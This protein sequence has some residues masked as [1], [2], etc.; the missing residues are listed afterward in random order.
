MY[1]LAVA[2]GAVFVLVFMVSL[3]IVKHFSDPCDSPA[4]VIL[5]NALTL[6]LALLSCFA[7]PLDVY[8]T[9]LSLSNVAFM[10]N[11][12]FVVFALVVLWVCLVV[13]FNYFYVEEEADEDA[14]TCERMGNAA[15]YTAFFFL[16]MLLLCVIGLA[17]RP[18]H[19][20]WVNQPGNAKWIRDVFDLEHAGESAL[21]FM[22]A[23]LIC[24]GSAGWVVYVGYGI[25]AMPM[26]LIRGRKSLGETRMEL[27]QDLA[28]V[29][30]RVRQLQS[31]PRPR[32]RDL[33]ELARLQKQE[34]IL[35]LTD[36]SLASI[37]VGC[38]SR[39]LALLTP[40]RVLL[41]VLLLGVSLAVLTSLALSSVDKALH[42]VC[43]MKCGFV[44]SKPAYFNPVDEALVWL[45]PQFPLDYAVFA[46]LV[47]FLFVSALYGVLTLGV[48]VLCFRVV[49]VKGR[50]TSPQGMLVACAVIMVTLLALNAELLALAPQYS[51]FGS[52]TAV[53]VDANS[54]EQN[55]VLAKARQF[56]TQVMADGE[57][58]GGSGSGSAGSGGSGSSSHVRCTIGGD[59]GEDACAMSSMARLLNSITMGM[60]FFSVVFYFANWAFLGI[61]ALT[62]LW[63]CLRKKDAGG[64][65]E[66]LEDEDDE[67]AT[68]SLL[69]T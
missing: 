21:M 36:D 40:F 66:L 56:T 12:Y 4:K 65:E 57:G 28:K 67:E 55:A 68:V 54:L 24:L 16:A 20:T 46:G 53:L 52:Q 51:S 9:S 37:R 49:R 47:G 29:R 45:A 38:V 62:L 61:A 1:I 6:T 25:I 31:K 60:P 41:G 30:E 44:V 19:E 13:P 42:S 7:L 63:S 15:K 10:K 14:P 32:R 58:V 48:R 43:G 22:I 11:A 18:G 26:N 39:C 2:L 59:H 33:I 34:R 50:A 64:Y 3:C 27:E 35:S 8:A 5:T 23:C 17:L 69:S